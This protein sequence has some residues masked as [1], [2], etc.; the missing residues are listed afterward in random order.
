MI[1]INF[2]NRPHSDIENIRKGYLLGYSYVTRNS[3]LN[4]LVECVFNL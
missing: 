1:T 3:K 4:A 2:F